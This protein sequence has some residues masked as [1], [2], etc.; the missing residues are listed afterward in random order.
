MFLI[1]RSHIH[2]ANLLTF[3]AILYGL[4]G[5]MNITYGNIHTGIALMI[6]GVWCDMLDGYIARKYKLQSQ[7]GSILDSFA[8]IFLYILP[9]ILIQGRLSGYDLIS[10]F[11]L[12]LFT[13]AGCFRL[14]YFTESGLITKGGKLHYPGFPVYLSHIFFILLLIGSPSGLSLSY[15]AIFSLLM[16]CDCN[17]PKISIFLGIVLLVILMATNILSSLGVFSSGF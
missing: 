15:I 10:G 17:V 6:V 16:V 4:W 12:S 14:A 3:L 5:S 9:I 8:D 13:L 11:I 2:S 1:R 7:L